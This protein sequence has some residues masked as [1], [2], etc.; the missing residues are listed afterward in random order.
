VTGPS[1]GVLYWDNFWNS[2]C[3]D[4]DPPPS[5]GGEPG[6][7]VRSSAMCAEEVCICG[8]S[9]PPEYAG[10][11]FLGGEYSTKS[12]TTYIAYNGYSHTDTQGSP[13]DNPTNW[14]QQ[15]H[16]VWLPGYRICPTEMDRSLECS[17]TVTEA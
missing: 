1:N 11:P 9:V 4:T 2:G 10:K 17:G 7:D 6:M 15:Q 13:C 16:I 8:V 3:P 12:G 14:A 5:C